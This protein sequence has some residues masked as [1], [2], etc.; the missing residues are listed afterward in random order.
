MI[1]IGSTDDWII[2]G[3]TE[4]SK[5]TRRLGKRIDPSNGCSFGSG[6]S[7]MIGGTRCAEMGGDWRT[8]IFSNIHYNII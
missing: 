1:I 7:P 5:K 2:I 3:S 4:P 8:Q 6:G